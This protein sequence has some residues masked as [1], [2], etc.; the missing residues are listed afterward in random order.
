[1][2]HTWASATIQRERLFF[3][4]REK[5]YVLSLEMTSHWGESQVPHTTEW[6]KKELSGL[7]FK[8]RFSFLER[9]EDETLI[10]LKKCHAKILLPILACALVVIWCVL[11]HSLFVLFLFFLFK[12]HFLEGGFVKLYVYVVFRL[13]NI[14]TWFGKG[15][16]GERSLQV[17]PDQ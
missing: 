15:W 14:Q 2:M 9:Y 1:M 8:G 16:K 6:E 13:C 4:G 11:H 12:C 7:T 10:Y 5:N 3:T 17:L